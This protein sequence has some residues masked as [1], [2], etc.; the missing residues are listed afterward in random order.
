MD[1]TYFQENL[2]KLIESRGKMIKDVA[3]DNQMTPATLSRY[4]SGH[5]TP[6]LPYVVRLAEYFNVSVDWILGINGDKF[7]VL[8]KEI[9][10]FAQLYSLASMDDRRVVQAVL[11]KYREEN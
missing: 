4:L 11:N 9:Q 8:P 1:Y 10:E 6:D 2:R 7:E 3:M 5:R